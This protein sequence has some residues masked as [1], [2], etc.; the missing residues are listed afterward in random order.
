MLRRVPQGCDLN[1]TQSQLAGKV[2]LP[3]VSKRPEDGEVTKMLLIGI[4][5]LRQ[6]QATID[7]RPDD[8]ECAVGR[9]DTAS[10]LITSVAGGQTVTVMVQPGSQ[11]GAISDHPHHRR[12]SVG[13][14][15]VP[16]HRQILR[17]RGKLHLKSA[18]RS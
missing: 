2:E 7:N 12:P 11:A 17:P 14:H 10:M 18:P 8:S 4:T 15:P 13:H 16:V 9:V 1:L 3:W 6:G 5:S